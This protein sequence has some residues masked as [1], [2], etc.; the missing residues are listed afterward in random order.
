MI[1]CPY[2]VT[3]FISELALNLGY[4]RLMN[5]AASKVLSLQLEKITPA[6]K[7]VEKPF[8]LIKMK[9]K[10]KITDKINAVPINDPDLYN[11]VAYPDSD[12]NEL[13]TIMS[14]LGISKVPVATS[15]WNRKLMGFIDIETLEKILE[16]V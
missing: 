3:D 9:M 15:P 14:Q 8:K 16:E 7:T 2:K 13:Y 5:N 1:G 4:H 10:K 6:K 11:I 12:I